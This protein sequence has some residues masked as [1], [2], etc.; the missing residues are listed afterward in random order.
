MRALVCSLKL[1]APSRSSFPPVQ[2]A[3]GVVRVPFAFYEWYKGH[4]G[5]SVSQTIIIPNEQD[6]SAYALQF[7]VA[8]WWLLKQ[9]PARSDGQHMG[10]LGRQD[11]IL[12]SYRSHGLIPFSHPEY[13]AQAFL[14]HP[15]HCHIPCQQHFSFSCQQ[16]FF[17][18]Y[19]PISFCLLHFI[20]PTCLYSF[21]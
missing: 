17:L 5:T 15:I 13:L 12:I 18:S 2:P 21:F 11:L 4:V 9:I 10:G 16:V 19:K 7:L 3:E 1:C 8:S 6:L 20:A 14:H